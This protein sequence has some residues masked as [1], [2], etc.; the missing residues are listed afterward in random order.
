[1]AIEHAFVRTVAARRRESYNQT[2]PRGR[3]GHVARRV[4]SAVT[5]QCC[6]HGA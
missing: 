6:D 3:A 1:M 5:G 4:G 2:Q